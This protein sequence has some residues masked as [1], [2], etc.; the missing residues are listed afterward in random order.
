MGSSAF[1]LPMEARGVYREMLS[2]AWRRGA[3]LPNDHE[4]IQRAIGCTPKEWRRAWPLIERFWQ[5]DGDNLINETQVEVYADAQARQD[6]SVKRAQAGAQ[7]RWKQQPKQVPERMVSG[8]AQ[9]MPTQCPP[10]PSPS[11]ITG[12]AERETPR[13]PEPFAASEPLDEAFERFKALYP[14]HRRVDNFLT[15]QRFVDACQSVTPAI[16]FAKLEEQKQSDEWRRGLIPAMQ[17]WFEDKHYE[18][19][20]APRQPVNAHTQPVA[21]VGRRAVV[22]AHE[23]L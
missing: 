4:A 22:P 19:D 21:F 2:Q 15:R 17:K 23:P 11:P 10:S 1:I 14:G 9:A 12:K 16:V 20:A 3:R 7:A 5:V 8:G 18:R 13:E 6:K